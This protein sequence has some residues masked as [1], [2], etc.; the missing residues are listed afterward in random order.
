MESLRQC[1]FTQRS[2]EIPQEFVGIR[3]DCLLRLAQPFRPVN[4]FR[5]KAIRL[6]PFVLAVFGLQAV[7]Q[8]S[9]PEDPARFETPAGGDVKMESQIQVV[10]VVDGQWKILPARAEDQS[11]EGFDVSYEAATG[12]R[13]ELKARWEATELGWRSDVSWNAPSEN[14]ET[15]VLLNLILPI[16]EADAVRLTSGDAT[17]EFS[18]IINQ[19]STRT[20]V[21][22]ITEFTLHG[23]GGKDILFSFTGEIETQT[24]VLGENLYLRV[25]LTHRKDTLPGTG[26]IRWTVDPQ[27]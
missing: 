12:D 27:E 21:G 18:K 13:I 16:V 24:M 9:S 8:S 4:S 3:N 19:E 7:A 17:V 20:S 23:P 26:E 5:V 22:G 10:S 11:E 6:L 25:F 1:V 2:S 15:F 14:P